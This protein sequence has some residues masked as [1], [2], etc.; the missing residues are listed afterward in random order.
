MAEHDITAETS[1]KEPAP[2]QEICG[3]FGVTGPANRSVE[4]LRA[5]TVFADAINERV[6]SAK[7]C[8]T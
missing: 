3:R 8:G 4:V 1:R 6:P 5:Q 7:G 2:A